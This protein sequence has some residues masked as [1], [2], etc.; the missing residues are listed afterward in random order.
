MRSK[1]TEKLTIHMPAKTRKL[2]TG[3][4]KRRKITLSQLIRERLGLTKPKA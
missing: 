1:L 4:A 2:L 3:E